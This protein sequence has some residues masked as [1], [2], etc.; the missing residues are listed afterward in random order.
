MSVKGFNF[1]G[2]VEKYDYDHLENKLEKTA[3]AKEFVENKA[4]AAG[5]MV[6]YDGK[7][8]SRKTNGV[9]A[10][11]TEANWI[12]TD[13]DARFDTIEGEVSDLKE[14]LSESDVL[15]KLLHDNVPDTVQNYTFTDGTVSRVEHKS[16]NT[17]KRSD[18]F[19]Y[20]T[21]SITEVRTLDSGESLT[22]VT[23]LSTLE[24]SVTYSAA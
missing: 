21:T 6:I 10:S 5:D 24:T 22:I 20:G 11:W 16:G 3:L 8:Y 1:G 14:D 13:I 2:G 18:V 9:D 7:L 4:Y 12:E 15:Q 19:T 17:V 23:N